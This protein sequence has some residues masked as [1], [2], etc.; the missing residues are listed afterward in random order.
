MKNKFILL[1]TLAIGFAGCEPEFEKEVTAD[2]TS[3][4]AN[5]KVPFDSALKASKKASK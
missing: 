3:G 2:Y 5:F 1:A 4:E